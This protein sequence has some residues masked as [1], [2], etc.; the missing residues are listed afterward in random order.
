M[1]FSGYQP[2]DKGYQP[3]GMTRPGVDLSGVYTTSGT[4]LDGYQ[5]SDEGMMYARLS[6]RTCQSNGRGNCSRRV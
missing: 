1:H 2:L 4:L 5:L 3:A 6:T